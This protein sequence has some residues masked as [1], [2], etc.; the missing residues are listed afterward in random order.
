M[1]SLFKKSPTRFC[2]DCRFFELRGSNGSMEMCMRDVKAHKD[3]N[4]VTG[5]VSST[6]IQGSLCEYERDSPYGWRCGPRA[7]FFKPKETV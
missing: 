7:K 4:L 6:N 3:V 2:I 1:F 5:K